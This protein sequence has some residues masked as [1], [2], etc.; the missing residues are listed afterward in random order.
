MKQ[1]AIA[2]LIILTMT[3]SG[4]LDLFV[5]TTTYESHATN[6][7]YSI[8][9][10]YE[11]ESQGTGDYEIHYD[12]DYPEVLLGQISTPILLYNTEYEP[13]SIGENDIVRWNISGAD[14]DSYTLGI[15]T[16]IT[17][18]AFYITDI[19]GA[20]A[21]TIQDI[22]TQH[23]E[24]MRQYTNAQAN[25]SAT[26][27]DPHNQQI[28][29]IAED[30]KQKTPTNNSYLL[31]KALFIWLKQNTDYKIHT[32][33][34]GGVQPAAVTFN[35]KTGDCDDLSYLYVSLCRAIKIP[36]RF[37]RGYLIEEANGIAQATSHAWTE[38][39]VGATI[40]NN[41]W[42]PVECASNSKNMDVQ[43][44]QNFGV[45]DVQHLRLYTDSGTNESLILSMSGISWKTYNQQIAVTATPFV[46]IENY[47][48]HEEQKLVI[49]DDATRSYE[50]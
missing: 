31:A 47:I 8:R 27:I 37:I 29:T 33:G 9:Y 19:T 42:I 41:G 38:I 2:I 25:D 3:L 48:I 1:A 36:A 26:F 15:S 34:D 24:L 23:P 7:S 28:K 14:T 30:I 49:T 40:G 50:Q 4:C 43:I 5:N 13:I 6:V 45:E 12:C 35:K 39:Y 20:H 32:T 10:G 21:L 18:E 44:H 11:I 16:E 17:T 46:D 22:Q